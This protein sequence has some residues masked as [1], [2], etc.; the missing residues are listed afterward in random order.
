MDSDNSLKRVKKE[1]G[2]EISGQEKDKTNIS[3]FVFS[4]EYKKPAEPEK[5]TVDLKVSKVWEENNNADLTGTSTISA[6]H[7]VS[8]KDAGKT[9]N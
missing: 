4:N 3:K 8:N 2:A 6:I 7:P 1:D 5:E 9:S